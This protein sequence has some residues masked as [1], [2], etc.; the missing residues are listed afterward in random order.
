[1]KHLFNKTV[2]INYQLG[3]KRYRATGFFLRYADEDYLITNRHVVEHEHGISPD[4]LRIVIQPKSRDANPIPRKVQLFTEDGQNRWFTSPREAYIDIAVI[5]LKFSLIETG[6]TAF[7]TQNILPESKDLELI[8]SSIVVLGYPERFGAGETNIPVARGGLISSEYGRNFQNE[9]K[10]LI[11]AK[12]QEG[13]SG[14]PVLL[15]PSGL[16]HEDQSDL[17][18]TRGD[19]HSSRLL[20]IH[21]G[22]VEYQ[23]RLDLHTIWYPHLIR[24]IIAENVS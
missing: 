2:N 16:F 24:E 9:P 23:N 6:N 11:E 17:F 22:P 14:S 7:S 15:K 8:G 18:T 20:G 12:L 3:E 19:G 5:P 13:M 4:H 10:F 21:S 1:M